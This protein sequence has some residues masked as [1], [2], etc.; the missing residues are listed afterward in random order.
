MDDI[1]RQQERDAIL[2]QALLA[3][4]QPTFPDRG[5]CYNCDE[6]LPLGKYC[7]SDCRE[8]H[9]KEVRLRSLHPVT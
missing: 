1:D 5:S 4:R 9:E 3:V 7:D 6:P 2:E 8:D